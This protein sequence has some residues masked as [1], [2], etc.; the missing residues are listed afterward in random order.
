MSWYDKLVKG[1]ASVATTA[2][3]AVRAITIA[4]GNGLAAIASVGNKVVEAVKAGWEYVRPAVERVQKVISSAVRTM[5][6]IPKN[7]IKATGQFVDDVHS[8]VR[9]NL[10]DPVI[11]SRTEENTQQTRLAEARNELALRLQQEAEAKQKAERQQKEH[12]T[13]EAEEQRQNELDEQHR[14]GFVRL[15]RQVASELR[16]L[17]G[18]SAISDFSTYLRVRTCADLT[19]KLSH[20]ASTLEGFR[21][22][23]EQDAAPAVASLL[24]ISRGEEISTHEWALLEQ[25]CQK[26]FG[27]T[28]IERSGEQLFAMWT[29][30]RFDCEQRVEELAISASDA[31]VEIIAAGQKQAIEGPLN[32][33][34]LLALRITRA[35]L[36]LLEQDQD[37]LFARLRELSLL[38]GVAEGL[39]Q[40][41]TGEEI[42]EIL[43]EDAQR[44]GELITSWHQGT[45]LVPED[46]EF[47][48]SFAMVYKS[49]AGRRARRVRDEVIV[50]A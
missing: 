16:I 49:R 34:D 11:P 9:K 22:L 31:E 48:Q 18:Q 12:E 36:A 19:V 50:V 13:R 41:M 1:V 4:V 29:G 25:L 30:E 43:Q 23:V 8:Q 38:S 7:V 14:A 40:V 26:E 35:R 33:D 5:A 6:E 10:G 20:R 27:S 15:T 3:R 46:T 17:L 45:T 24:A 32:N 37:R 28:L 47:L 2:V 39:L 21:V 44:A 42:E